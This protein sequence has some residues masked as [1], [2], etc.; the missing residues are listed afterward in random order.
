MSVD[1]MSLFRVSDSFMNYKVQS[2]RDYNENHT[3]ILIA[4]MRVFVPLVLSSNRISKAQFVNSYNEWLE[5]G[6]GP[7]AL[8]TVFLPYSNQIYSILA[9]IQVEFKSVLEESLRQPK[10]DGITVDACYKASC[11]L[12]ASSIVFASLPSFTVQIF[13]YCGWRV[14]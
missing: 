7:L 12:A 1:T 9:R 8:A 11:K 6:Y 3:K 2:A 5:H 14:S 10:T 4:Y 13:E